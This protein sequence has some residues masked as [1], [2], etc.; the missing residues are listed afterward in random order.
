[1]TNREEDR[2]GGKGGQSGEGKDEG[3]EERR[4]GRKEGLVGSSCSLV[5]SDWRSEG[6]E[7]DSET[8]SFMDTD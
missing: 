3:K 2:E 4:E 1:M 8:V 7:R 5:S 6:G